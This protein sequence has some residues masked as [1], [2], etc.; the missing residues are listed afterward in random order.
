MPY[1]VI[2]LCSDAK[3]GGT[4]EPTFRNFPS[5]T[6]FLRG[7]WIVGFTVDLGE[8]SPPRVL[9]FGPLGNTFLHKGGGATL[10]NCKK[11]KQNMST[12]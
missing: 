7:A 6:N 4:T 11:G 5:P 12:I 8:L 9:R 2:C 1:K 10:D 3:R